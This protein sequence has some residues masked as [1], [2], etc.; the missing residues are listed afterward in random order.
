[1]NKMNIYFKTVN[2]NLMNSESKDNGNC[3]FASSSTGSFS[4]SSSESN[5]QKRD[6]TDNYE[7]LRT[8]SELMNHI[9]NYRLKTNKSISK[10]LKTTNISLSFDVSKY[11]NQI[12]NKTQPQNKS[13][14]TTPLALRAG[15]PYSFTKSFTIKEYENNNTGSNDDQILPQLQTSECVNENKSYEASFRSFNHFLLR[16]L[17]KDLNYT[18]KTD[19]FNCKYYYKSTKNV[20]D[21]KYGLQRMKKENEDEMDRNELIAYW[22]KTESGNV[23]SGLVSLIND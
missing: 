9:D 21:D 19:N 3:K 11:N 12:K 18:N 7:N 4:S 10:V 16:G 20:F 15:S 22:Y 23:Y 2:I 17:K 8:D 6:K 13:Q 1:M 5:Y 14:S